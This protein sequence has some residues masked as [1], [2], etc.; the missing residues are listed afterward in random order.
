MWLQF[1]LMG[2]TNFMNCQA[3]VSSLVLV[4]D[5]V[6]FT[7]YKME[8]I[9]YCAREQTQLLNHYSLDK[10]QLKQS[11]TKPKS[12]ALISLKKVLEH[13]TSLR[14]LSNHKN[15]MRGSQGNK[16]LCFQLKTEK[17]KLLQL[18]KISKSNLNL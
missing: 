13:C 2:R 7:D 17:R 5:Q 14:E 6:T 16:K 8:N 4:S 10:D 12:I 9:Y 15:S 11:L 3:F 18:T 1:K